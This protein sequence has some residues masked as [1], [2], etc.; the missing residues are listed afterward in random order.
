MP[1]CAP[2]GS[3]EM[4]AAAIAR[5]A[6][7]KAVL[8]K[9][10]MRRRIKSLQELGGYENRE[11]FA[12]A[13]GIDLRRMTYIIDNPEACKL[14]EAVAIQTLA[15]QYDVKVFEMELTVPT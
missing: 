5:R 1:K 3:Q 11:S 2:L 13:I 6:G 15:R 10:T 7:S 4:K 8:S 12:A 9:D 14:S